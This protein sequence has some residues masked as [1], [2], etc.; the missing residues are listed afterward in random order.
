[1]RTITAVIVIAYLI[2]GIY[3]YSCDDKGY[4]EYLE[5]YS[6][7]CGGDCNLYER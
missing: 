3:A 1:M 7:K 6:S 2:Y 4:S 5:N